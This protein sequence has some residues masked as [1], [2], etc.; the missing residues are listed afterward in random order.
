[1]KRHKKTRKDTRRNEKYIIKCEKTGFIFTTDC[2]IYLGIITTA[3]NF[4]QLKGKVNQKCVNNE[5][6]ERVL[7]LTDEKT[8]RSR[9]IRVFSHCI[10]SLWVSFRV[11][12][13]LF[14]SFRVLSCLFAF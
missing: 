9:L 4:N 2:F 5:Y 11:F 14:A 6:Q 7:N 13:C 8:P 10:M 3:A 12:L 1:M